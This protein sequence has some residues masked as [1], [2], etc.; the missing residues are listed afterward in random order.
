MYQW[1][2]VAWTG[3]QDWLE[4]SLEIGQNQNLIRNRQNEIPVIIIEVLYYLS[5]YNSLAA[6]NSLCLKS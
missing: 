4:M 6:I 1:L 3:A 5:G 2:T